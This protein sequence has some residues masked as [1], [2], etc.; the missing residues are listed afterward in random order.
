MKASELV[1]ELE[2][3]IDKEGD[4]EIVSPCYDYWNGSYIEEPDVVFTK[5]TIKVTDL[6]NSDVKKAGK[7]IIIG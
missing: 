7:F 3:I 2:K 4:A 5:N 1:K 6:V